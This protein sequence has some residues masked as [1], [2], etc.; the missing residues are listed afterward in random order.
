MNTSPA[1]IRTLIVDDEAP[2]RVRLKDL[3]EN[4]GDVGKIYEADHGEEAVRLI[5]EERP[6]LVLLDMQM[7]DLDGFGVVEAIGPEAMPLTVFVT[8]F[9]QH[10]VRAFEA[11]AL[12]YILKPFSDERM[13]AMLS[14][15]KQR[16][17]QMQMQSFG[18]NL[19]R[20]MAALP[21]IEGYQDRIA[22]KSDGITRFLN[23]SEIDWIEAAGVYVML[24]IGGKE[25]LHRRSLASMLLKLDPRR[26]VRV[27]RSAI[28]NI[29]S[30]VQLE[31]LSHGEFE[32]TTKHGG[33][34]RVSRTFRSLLER[35]LGES[36]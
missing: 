31:A 16:L 29:E 25:F 21:G 30:I 3:L 35:R 7:P 19:V 27:H 20:A 36:L 5:Q 10:A 9:G 24:H 8:A 26:F 4:D 12:D 1:S 22:I 14:R 33:R 32:A 2:A 11:N 13:Q 23:A 18:Q 15:A 17:L 34:L 28:V 6:D